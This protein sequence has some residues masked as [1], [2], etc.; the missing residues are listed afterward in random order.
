[1]R[2]QWGLD[3]LL[4]DDNRKNRND[5]RHHAIDAVTIGCISR[6]MLNRVAQEAAR[7]E[8]DGA[9]RVVAGF[10]EPFEGFRD[11]VRD[12]L[13]SV[14]VSHKPE[15]GKGGA[16]HE[17]TNYGLVRN[18]REKL[19]GNLVHRKPLESLNPNEIGRVRDP[20][21]GAAL[22]QVVFEVSGGSGKPEQK[23]LSAALIA[24]AKADAERIAARTGK[25]RNPIRHVRLLKP[26]ANAVE[27]KDRR[28]GKAYRA[29]V[30]DENWCLDVVSFKDGK[31][32]HVWKAFAASLFEVNQPGWRP[33]WEREKMGGKLVMRLHKGDLI[34]IEDKDGVRRV[35]RVVRLNAAAERV[36]LVTHYEAGDFQQRHEDAED[37]FRWDLAGI[38]SM[39]E[40]NP[41][42][43]SIN[44]T[45]EKR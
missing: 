34:E 39:R 7:N 29:V 5:H 23:A 3:S 38:S 31:G 36:Y 15:H 19:I 11:Q 8:A 16:L 17:D 6:S 18:E 45:G 27:L 21:L 24:W 1:M 20:D 13:R 30:P 32:G 9:A 4:G 12:Q 43:L 37:P 26:K 40:R 41:V 10:P 25:P 28:T 2:R 14:I 44:A 22:Q 33:L 35:K 42:K